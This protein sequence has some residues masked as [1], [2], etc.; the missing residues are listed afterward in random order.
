MF[1]ALLL[2]GLIAAPIATAS[3][4]L[5]TTGRTQ[6]VEK[7]W[8][9][10]GRLYFEN[11]FRERAHI[12]AEQRRRIHICSVPMDDV[13]ENAAIV[14]ALQRRS[15]VIVQ[16]SLV[17]GF[18]LTVAEAMWKGRPTIGS[19]VGGIQDQIEPGESGS[20]ID[21][22]DPEDL[23]AAVVS[24]PAE[25]GRAALM[26]KNG[27]RSNGALPRTDLPHLSAQ[28]HPQT[29]LTLSVIHSLRR[30]QASR[31]ALSP[32]RRSHRTGAARAAPR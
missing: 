11:L 9:W 3:L 7:V 29:A 23:G 21:P 31:L 14:N 12:P 28:H 15:D 4:L 26:G 2:A 1:S 22:S 5:P 20:L 27:R 30:S 6:R 13:D 18:G 16:K 17:E 19:R 24:L 32:H 10:L 8:R 25:P